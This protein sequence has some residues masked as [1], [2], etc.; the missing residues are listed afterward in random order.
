MRQDEIHVAG[1]ARTTVG[2]FDCMR[3][4]LHGKGIAAVFERWF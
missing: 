4:I 3:G 1:M 2:T